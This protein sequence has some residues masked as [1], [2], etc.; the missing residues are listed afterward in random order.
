MCSGCGHGALMLALLLNIQSAAGIDPPTKAQLFASQDNLLDRDGAGAVSVLVPNGST[1]QL[2]R[3]VESTAAELTA[4]V[5]EQLGLGPL[6]LLDRDGSLLKSSAELSDGSPLMALPIGDSPPIGDSLPAQ[7]SPATQQDPFHM[8]PQL[9]SLPLTSAGV[10]AF[11]PAVKSIK[12][13][14]GESWN[15]PNAQLWLQ[16]EGEALAVL[17]FEPSPSKCE[18]IRNSSARMSDSKVQ[19]NTKFIDRG[20]HLACVGLSDQ[21]PTIQ[22]FYQTTQDPGTSSFNRPVEMQVSAVHRVPVLRLA[23]FLE[24]VDWDRFA[25]VDQLKTDCQ[26]HDLKVLKGAG[27]WLS[28]R[29]VW[30]TPEVF[31]DGYITDY[32]SDGKDGIRVAYGSHR[33]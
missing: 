13:S 27:R 15:A 12:I 18:V 23:D 20:Y 24:R 7:P 19:L 5:S 21:P 33:M 32:S 26:G 6:R 9:A 25:Y 4:E 17:A 2:L 11:P 28:D 1:L 31:C 16:R 10:F 8:F 3:T 14:V 29:V 22:S 30:V